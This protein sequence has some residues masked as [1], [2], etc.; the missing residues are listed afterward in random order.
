[1][2]SGREKADLAVVGASVLNVYTGEL[3]HNHTI[4]LKGELIAYTGNA[5]DDIIGPDTVVINAEGK[6]VIP[7]FIEGHTHLA[8]CK[9]SPY[10]FLRRAMTGGTTTIITETME[11]FPIAGY[12]GVADFLDALTDQPI[13]IFGT[14]PA[15]VSISR[16][17]KI[18]GKDILKK[19]LS[20]ADVLGLGEAYWQGVMQRQDEFL[21]GF[22]E[23]L[24]AGKRVEGHS[25]GAR[26]RK[27]MAYT[28]TGV[29]SCHEPVNPEEVLERLRLGLYVMIREGSTRRD[30]A[31]ISEIKGAGLDSRRMILVTDGVNPADL[32]EKGYM[33]NVVQKAVDLGINPV[34]A[35]RMATLNA[36]EYFGLDR[37]TGGIAPGRH[38]DMLIIPS[39]REIRPEYVISR[40][41]IIARNGDLLVSP[42]PHAFSDASLHSISMPREINPSD[43]IIRADPEKGQVRV[44]VIDLVTGLVTREHVTS[45][46]VVGGEIKAD[47][48]KDLLKVAAIDR[49]NAAGRLFTGLIRGF[50]ITKGAIATSS[51][52]DSSDVV[53]IGTN[54]GDMAC[55]VNRVCNLQGGAVVCA[56]SR[57]LYEIPLPIFGLMSDMPL[58]TLARKFKEMAALVKGLGFPFEDPLLTLAT[59][60]GAAIPFIRMCEE[61]LVNIKDGRKLDL[62]A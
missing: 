43:F 62:I 44:R 32:A 3:L 29:T 14:A 6:T 52:W 37:M 19:L 49:A 18:P 59:L 58:D 46:P 60:T 8:D 51:A 15:M 45:V 34:D 20:R 47:V 23:A 50:H 10:E 56:D 42:K 28:A 61:G 9:Y 24:N 16:N 4:A 48:E 11:P 53:V 39:I 2:L 27:L 40:G 30:L 17:I 57:V 33:E 38:G 5:P 55:A 21:P 7:G 36:A 12:D 31:A 35:V 25:A 26:G 54:E 22:M 41:K 13:K 1:M